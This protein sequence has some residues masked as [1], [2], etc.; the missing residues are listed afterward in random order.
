MR[1]AS[2]RKI[3]ISN[4]EGVGVALFV[5][6]CHFHCKNCF[7]SCTWDFS[8]GYEWTKEVKKYFFSLIDRKY[9]DRV[10]ILGGEPLTDEN[11]SEVCEIIHSIRER[12]PDKKIW[13]YT[14]YSFD[15]I[16]TDSI[17]DFSFT[18]ESNKYVLARS[19]AVLSVDVVVDG[20]FKDELKDYSLHWKGS[21]NQRVIDVKKTYKK[22]S[23]KLSS[24][25][26]YCGTN[27]QYDTFLNECI[28][29]IK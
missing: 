10:T 5:Q 26:S 29:E 16:V 9:I 17:N 7:N 4:G 8:G 20:L 19:T 11:V 23:D 21:S 1:Y 18:G 24:H 15:K 14:G 22:Y 28:V 6:G 25:I 3:D 2:I 12:F 27:Y 13:L